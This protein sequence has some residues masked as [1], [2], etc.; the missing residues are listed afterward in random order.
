MTGHRAFVSF[1]VMPNMKPTIHIL[2]K[3]L[4]SDNWYK[5][6]RYTFELTRTDGVTQTQQR[7]AYDRG[8]GAAILLYNPEQQTVILTRQFRMPTFVNGNPDGMM[9]EACAGLLDQERMRRALGLLGAS[10]APMARV[11]AEAGFSDARSL[12]RAIK[13]W[14]GQTP[15]ALRR[16]GD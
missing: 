7:E 1:R 3:K 2:E 9:I 14:T 5:L 8:N 6:W 10:E 15:S 11:A 4:L 12:R 16:H 13:R